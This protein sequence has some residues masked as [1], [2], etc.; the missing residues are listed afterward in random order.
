MLH[1]PPVRDHHEQR[2]SIPAPKHAREAELIQLDPL[3][4]LATFA[5]T[6]AGWPAVL[7]D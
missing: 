4:H 6:D 3:Q 2:P 5:N 1:A 7:D